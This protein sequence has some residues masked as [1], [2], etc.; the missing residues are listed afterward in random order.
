MLQT[1]RTPEE[2]HEILFFL[3]HF[4]DGFSNTMMW[5]FIQRRRKT[6]A[7]KLNTLHIQRVHTSIILICISMYWFSQKIFQ[8]LLRV[9]RPVNVTRCSALGKTDKQ[10][11]WSEW[12]KAGYSE[13]TDII[14]KF[15][16]LAG[17]STKF[18][19]PSGRAVQGVGL[20][21]FAC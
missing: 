20:W 4:F 12:R 21:P 8:Q 3:T 18:A 10:P 16:F 7:A 9:L 19:G 17:T 5:K 1:P 13:P 6:K 2:I 15:T 11:A 14:I